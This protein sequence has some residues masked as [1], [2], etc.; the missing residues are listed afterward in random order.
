M[1]NSADAVVPTRFLGKSSWP[2]P[3]G[4]WRT[5]WR[6]VSAAD[7]VV[8]NNARHL[9]PVVA[10][11]LARWRGRPAF[12]VVH[13]SGEGPYRGSATFGVLRRLFEKTLGRLAL[14]L[15]SPVSVSQAGVEGVRDLYGRNA[16]YLPYPLRDIRPVQSAPS[17]EADEPFRITWVGRLFPEKDPLAAVEAVELVRRQRDA[18][19]AV[20]GAGPLR[21][22]IEELARERPWLVVH[23]SR[24]WEEVQLQ[25]AANHVCLATS[26]ADNVQVAVLEAMSRGIP[27]VSTRVGDAHS[28]YLAPSIQHLCVTPGDPEATARALLD[29]ATSYDTYWNE[30]AANGALLRE[31]HAQAGE[32]LVRLLTEAL[33]N[34]SSAELASPVR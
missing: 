5:L 13:G 17:Y 12:L 15:A 9:L 29:L 10:V 27:T 25:Q 7:V 24:G 11:L 16:S 3:I 2:L 8:A 26:I 21:A 30:F 23:G 4:G 28:Y 32:T 34:S 14:R 6:E 20:Y 22:L 1:D 31:R 19:L 18:V 33:P